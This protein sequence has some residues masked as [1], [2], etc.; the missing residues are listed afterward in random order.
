L[1]E[2]DGISGSEPGR[3]FDRGIDSRMILHA[4]PQ[5][6][7]GGLSVRVSLPVAKDLFLIWRSFLMPWPSPTV[8]FSARR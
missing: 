1:A 6:D 5:G 2:L 3:D 8:R 7:D 4:V